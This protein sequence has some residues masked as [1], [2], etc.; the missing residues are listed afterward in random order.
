M[1]ALILGVALAMA[2][3]PALAEFKVSSTSVKSGSPMA[4]AQV[5]GS[6]NG[7]NVSPALTWSGEMACDRAALIRNSFS[8]V[9]KAVS[10]RPMLYDTLRSSLVGLG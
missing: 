3:T 4:L 5:L 2:V 9:A 1:R 8:L 7:Q 10:M 6:C